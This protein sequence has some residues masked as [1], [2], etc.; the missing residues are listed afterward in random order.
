ME[1]VQ[2][3][4]QENLLGKNFSIYGSWEKPL[5]LAKDVAEWIEHSNSS[6]MVSDA[7]LSKDE[8]VKL[9]I[10]TLTNSYSALYLTEDGL[11]EVLMQSRKPIAKQFKKGVKEILKNIRKTGEYSVNNKTENKIDL[12]AH[13]LIAAQ[14]LINECNLRNDELEKEL[15]QKEVYTE[16]LKAT[17]KEVTPKAEYVDTVLKSVDTYTTT[18]IA[19]ELGFKNGKE[20]NTTLKN[21]GVIYRQS[22]RWMLKSK[23]CGKYYTKTKTYPYMDGMTGEQHTNIYMVWTEIGRKFLHEFFGKT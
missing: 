16:K 15:Q 1:N 13:A 17:I 18:Q 8:V 19:K 5:F 7:N 21:A 6:K 14:E 10:G 23:Y 11:Y 3:L 2:V 20:L 12:F 4:K 9:R 22:D